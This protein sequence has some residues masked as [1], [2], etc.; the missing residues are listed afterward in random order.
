MMVP[1]WDFPELARV[2][3]I[4]RFIG[5]VNYFRDQV[6]ANH[7]DLVMS[8][9][10]YLFQKTANRIKLSEPAKLAYFQKEIISQQT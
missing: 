5:L 6:Y 4:Q 1:P 8:F 3:Q 2:K 10:V 7:S 9:Q